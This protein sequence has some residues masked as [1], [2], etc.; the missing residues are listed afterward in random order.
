MRTKRVLNNNAVM[1]TDGAQV[2]V[3]M[4]RGIGYGKRPGDPVDHALISERFIPDATTSLERL[5]AFLTDTPLEIVRVAHEIASLARD[6]LDIRISQALVLPLADHIAYA[7]ERSRTDTHFLYPLRWEITQVYPQ[8]LALG[9]DAV[10]LIRR[11]LGVEV[12]EDESVAIAMHI[13]NAQ[14]AGENL[15]PT[16]EMTAKLNNILRVVGQMMK[17]EVDYE[18]MS[19]TRFITHLRYLFVRLQTRSQ[20]EGEVAVVRDAVMEAHPDA[21]RTAGRIRYLLTVG[22]QSLSE[23][24]ITY[25]TLHIA[26]LAKTTASTK[27]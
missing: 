10:D 7:I 6:R 18:S 4:G 26:R 1:V 20:F 15:G 13:V 25:L 12:T 3:V 5:V 19:A 11:R 21:Y 14:F 16:L 2:A 24:E 9:R 8:E 17:I 27:K 22:D 23:D